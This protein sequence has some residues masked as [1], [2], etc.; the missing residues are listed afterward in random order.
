MVLP[1]SYYHGTGGDSHS[2]IPIDIADIRLFD[3]IISTIELKLPPTS[4]I[5]YV[6]NVR[7]VV[8]GDSQIRRNTKRGYFFRNN[9]GWGYM[10]HNECG[11]ISKSRLTEI[12]KQLKYDA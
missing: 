10:C 4:A 5:E 11:L 7:C 3:S 8:C 2:R 12:V 9:T 1:T 6:A